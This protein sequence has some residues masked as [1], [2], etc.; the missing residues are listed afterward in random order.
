MSRTS[1]AATVC[2]SVHTALMAR[3]ALL[4]GFDGVISARLLHVFA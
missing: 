3:T 1:T 4:V 2:G